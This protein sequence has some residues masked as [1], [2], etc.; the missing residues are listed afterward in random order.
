LKKQNKTVA[1]M[2]LFV[3]CFWFLKIKKLTR[4]APKTHE[5]RNR[6]RTTRVARERE[7]G[8]ER[9]GDCVPAQAR[10]SITPPAVLPNLVVDALSVLNLAPIS[11][12]LLHLFSICS[13]D[14]LSPGRESIL[15]IFR[16]LS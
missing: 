8:R 4:N 2:L 10:S 14:Q 9:K 15:M 5:I 3:V 11:G 16:F 1:T 6:L 13:C 12:L 7:R